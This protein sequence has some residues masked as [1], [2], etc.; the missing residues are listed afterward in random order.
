MVGVVDAL[1]ERGLIERRR[2]IDRRTNGLWLTRA[3]RTF[4]ARLRQRIERHENRVAGRL[5]AAERSQLLA[6]L[7]KLGQ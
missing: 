3:G 6:L 5:T 7:E 1:E 4:A 2:G